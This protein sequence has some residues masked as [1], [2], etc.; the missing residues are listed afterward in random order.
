[1]V[2][3]KRFVQK[4][5]TVSSLVKD[6]VNVLPYNEDVEDLERNY[7]ELY[8]MILDIEEIFDCIFSS[9]EK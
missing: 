6:V 1:M 5:A 2:N 7:G 4:A 8:S 3:I 9:A